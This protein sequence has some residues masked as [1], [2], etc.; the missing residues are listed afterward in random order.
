MNKETKNEREWEKPIVEI[1]RKLVE[2]V[3]ARLVGALEKRISSCESLEVASQVIGE[4][5][6]YLRDL[7]EGQIYGPYEFLANDFSTYCRRVAPRRNF[8]LEYDGPYTH[9]GDLL[10]KFRRK[11]KKKVHIFCGELGISTNTLSDLE[12]DKRA[13]ENFNSLNGKSKHSLDDVKKRILSAITIEP[14]EKQSEVEALPLYSGWP[15]HLVE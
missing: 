8:M 6:S 12:K 5:G 2:R 4:F 3:P 9:L 15:S 7:E 11:F 10:G 14:S 13:S 1:A